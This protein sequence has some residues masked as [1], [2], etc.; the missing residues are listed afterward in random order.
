M[1]RFVTGACA[2]TVAGVV[3]V[4]S[5]VVAAAC[6]AEPASEGDSD[7]RVTYSPGSPWDG[8]G[9][10]PWSMDDVEAFDDYDIYWVGPAFGPYNLQA[11][12]HTEYDGAPDG[13]D[14]DMVSF[15]YGRCTPPPGAD[16]CSVPGTIQIQP[17]CLVPP[18]L[19]P[20]SEGDRREVM[21]DGAVFQ[22][23]PRGTAHI[24]TGGVTITLSAPADATLVDDVIRGL[25]IANPEHAHQPLTGPDLSKCDPG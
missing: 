6:S 7:G 19:L 17:I 18:G 2:R 14:Q 21:G 23:S 9:M 3:A 12:G 16:S 24:W 4:G 15:M 20:M 11:V 10:G 5:V 22:R 25:R 1:W 8:K 13:H